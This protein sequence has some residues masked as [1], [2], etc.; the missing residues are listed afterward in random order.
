MAHKNS[1]GEDHHLHVYCDNDVRMN[2]L[3][4]AHALLN[5]GALSS[6]SVCEIVATC[7]LVPLARHAEKL[8]MPFYQLEPLGFILTVGAHLC[9]NLSFLFGSNFANKVA[10]KELISPKSPINRIDSQCILVANPSLIPYLACRIRTP[11]ASLECLEN[12]HTVRS[13]CRI[14]N[15]VSRHLGRLLTSVLVVSC[16]TA[17][18]NLNELPLSDIQSAAGANNDRISFLVA[19]DVPIDRRAGR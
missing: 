4:D 6:C 5:S 11:C 1:S 10:G 2:I 15:V 7:N 13:C 9:I 12:Q 3:L 14:F 18:Q 16:F 17:V 19:A 8:L